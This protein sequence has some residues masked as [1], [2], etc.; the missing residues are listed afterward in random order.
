MCG[1][2]VID[3]VPE[4]LGKLSRQRRLIYYP[5]GKGSEAKSI[6]TDAQGAFCE[7]VKSGT[8]VVKVMT[9]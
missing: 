8:Y 1:K 4:S 5:Q 2:V 9:E 6:Q 3:R 7:N